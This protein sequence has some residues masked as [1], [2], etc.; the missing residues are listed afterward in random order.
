MVQRGLPVPVVVLVM[1][2]SHLPFV[3]SIQGYLIISLP[4]FE[5]PASGA[6]APILSASIRRG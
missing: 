1:V 2:R 4:G 3:F 6:E 5:H